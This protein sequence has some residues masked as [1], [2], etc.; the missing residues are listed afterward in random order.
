MNTAAYF[1]MLRGA[2]RRT[3]CNSRPLF[4]RTLCPTIPTDASVC[5]Y[6]VRLHSTS[7]ARAD[8]DPAIL[9]LTHPLLPFLSLTKTACKVVM[10]I[11]IPIESMSVRKLS[12]DDKSFCTNNG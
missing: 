12:R 3:G 2:T 4:A 1:S 10:K 8:F 9:I 6:C 11:S 5:G 7:V